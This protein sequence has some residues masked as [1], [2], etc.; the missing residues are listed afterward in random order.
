MY[1]K[2]TLDLNE[3]RPYLYGSG[4][5]RTKADLKC[6]HF[7]PGQFYRLY[8]KVYNTDIDTTSYLIRYLLF[9]VL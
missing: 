8:L 5:F 9:S 4:P 1:I 6:L 3:G 2:Y 7:R